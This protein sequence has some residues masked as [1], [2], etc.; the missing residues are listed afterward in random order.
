MWCITC[1]HR[2]SNSH[3]SGMVLRLHQLQAKL[4][5]G[6]LSRCGHYTVTCQLLVCFFL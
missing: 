6:W 3:A 5:G 2:C 1:M 4:V